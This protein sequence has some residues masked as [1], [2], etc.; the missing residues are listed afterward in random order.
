MCVCYPRDG[1]ILGN[2]SPS[3]C[4]HCLHP[5]YFI[6][7]DGDSPCG[8]GQPSLSPGHELA[9]HWRSHDQHRH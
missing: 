6:P 4:H 1:A 3:P 5:H 7:Y 2:R 9:S 8:G